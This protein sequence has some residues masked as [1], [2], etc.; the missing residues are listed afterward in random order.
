M[1]EATR[2]EIW[3]QAKAAV[4]EKY[5]TFCKNQYIDEV[6]KWRLNFLQCNFPPEMKLVLQFKMLLI[7]GA[8][9]N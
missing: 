9:K 7:K 6:M 3:D 4:M 1:L 5:I 2:E 8:A